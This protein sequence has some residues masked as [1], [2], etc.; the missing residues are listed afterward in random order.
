[1][2]KMPDHASRIR[3]ERAIKNRHVNI[4]TRILDIWCTTYNLEMH[5]KIRR[6]DLHRTM[7]QKRTSEWT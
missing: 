5:K 1:M 3:F 2:R 6:L 4:T 7:A